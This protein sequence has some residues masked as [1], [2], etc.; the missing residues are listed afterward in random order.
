MKV[1]TFM[2]ILSDINDSAR[3]IGLKMEAGDGPPLNINA[4][5]AIYIKSYPKIMLLDMLDLLDNSRILF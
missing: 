2:I 1:I 5:Q 3:K 4:M